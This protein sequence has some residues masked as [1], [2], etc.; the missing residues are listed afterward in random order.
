MALPELTI[1]GID[2]QKKAFTDTLKFDNTGQPI[3]DEF[4]SDGIKLDHGIHLLYELSRNTSNNDLKILAILDNIAGTKGL[5][6]DTRVAVVNGIVGIVLDMWST[7]G[8]YREMDNI[9]NKIK[10]VQAGVI[11]EAL[12]NRGDYTHR[13]EEMNKKIEYLKNRDIQAAKIQQIQGRE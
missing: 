8:H 11:V 2:S 6:S 1:T 4:L 9:I 3:F 10:T 13:I 7:R 12:K 5:P